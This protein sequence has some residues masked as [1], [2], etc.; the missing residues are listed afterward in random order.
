MAT[1]TTTQQFAEGNQVTADKL[2]NITNNSA[3]ASTVVD[4]VTTALDSVGGV[5][6]SKIIVADGGITKE[7]LNLT[8]TGV[9]QNIAVFKAVQTI[10]GTETD[11][12]LKIRTPASTTDANSPFEIETGNGLK[13]IVDSHAVTIDSNGKTLFGNGPI[14]VS[15]TPLSQVN[16]NTDDALGGTSGNQQNILRL[17]ENSSHEDSLLFT[18]NRTADGSDWT[19]AAHR[20]QRKVNSTK[21]GYIQFGHYSATNGGLITFGENET[22]RMRIDAEGQVG[23]GTTTPTEALQ[24]AGDIKATNGTQSVLL[25]DT[26]SIEITHSSGPFIDFKNNAPEDKDCRIF[27]D[28][29][30]LGFQVGGSSAV[31]TK[32]VLTSDGKVGIGNNV[33]PT[34]ELHVVSNSNSASTTLMV[35]NQGTAQANIKVKNSEGRFALL[36]DGGEFK[37]HDDDDGTRL[38]ID[39]DGNVGIGDTTPDGKLH[40]GTGNNSDGTDIDIVIG[41]STANARQA[42]ITKK[43]QSSDR[44]LE[45]YAS[46]STSDEDIRFFTDTGT[47]RIRI[48]AGGD[49]GI[50][51][52]DPAAKLEVSGTLKATGDVDFDSDLNVDG[53]AQIDGNVNINGNFGFDNTDSTTVVTIGTNSTRANLGGSG[54]SDHAISTELAIK[55]YV[56]AQITS[57]ILASKKALYPVGSIFTSASSNHNTASNVASALGF[58]T[59]TAYGAGRVLVG[60]ASSGTFNTLNGETGA[61]TVTLADGQVPVRDH[62]HFVFDASSDTQAPGSVTSTFAASFKNTSFGSQAYNIQKTSRGSGASK[63]D[64]GLT[65]NPIL[66]PNASAHN[67]IQPSVVVYMWKRTA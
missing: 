55:T 36:T 41:G 6:N 7:K 18:A 29:D 11:R 5:A 46:G 57:N 9:S 4:G 67:N 64:A 12:S 60:K 43:I 35:E 26:G 8:A 52:T 54:S 19:T 58:G 21:M 62:T 59:W 37:I 20:I 56:D 44:A 13:F 10:S 14:G 65:S 3:F 61:E 51:T 39:T 63:A 53:S 22:E 50:G 49:V 66:P 16:I 38:S 40:V 17:Q 47:E 1:I 31:A 42:I 34:E 2:N 32:M 30:G 45:I 24:V 23:I 28:S 33:T 48:E 27:Q 25:N 15:D